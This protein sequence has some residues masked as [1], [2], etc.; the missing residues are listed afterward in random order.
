MFNYSVPPQILGSASRCCFLAA[1]RVQSLLFFT[2]ID[3]AQL[4]CTATRHS[5]C[6]SR[7]LGLLLQRDN[8]ED[9]MTRNRMPHN[10]ASCCQRA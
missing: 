7:W 4:L 8:N 1:S 2:A 9:M 5:H 3:S 10:Q 6:Y